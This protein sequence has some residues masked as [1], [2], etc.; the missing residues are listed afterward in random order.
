MNTGEIILFIVLLL[1]SLGSFIISWFQFKERGFLLN[2]SYLYTSKKSRETMNKRP[3]Y[4]QSAIVFLL[5]GIIFSFNTLDIMINS[6]WLFYVS[7]LIA[8]IAIVYALVS[9]IS[10]ERKSDR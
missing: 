2:N 10:I 5:I 8:V 9:S 3:Y 4:R 6:R 7:M 1:I